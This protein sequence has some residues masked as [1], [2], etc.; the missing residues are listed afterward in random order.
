MV[1]VDRS[2]L[3]CMLLV[4][5]RIGSGRFKQA[6]HSTACAL[7]IAQV[8]VAALEVSC[9]RWWWHPSIRGPCGSPVS[10]RVVSVG[11]YN[12]YISLYD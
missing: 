12:T 4:I 9:H 6:C 10:Y 3:S 2:L 7:G 1:H 5:R 11:E 8:V